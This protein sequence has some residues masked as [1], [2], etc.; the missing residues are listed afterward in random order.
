[1]RWALLLL[2]ACATVPPTSPSRAIAGQ[3]A[4]CYRTTQNHAAPLQTRWCW[5]PAVERAREAGVTMVEVMDW[6]ATA[7]F[8]SGGALG[9]PGDCP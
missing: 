4:A 5:C 9:P 8:E 2:V 3:L 1:M 6:L 7:Q